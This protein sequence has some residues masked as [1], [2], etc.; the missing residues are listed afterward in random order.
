MVKSGLRRIG[1][2][3]SSNL[4]KLN[5]GCSEDEAGSSGGLCSSSQDSGLGEESDFDPAT[6]GSS[7]SPRSP[8]PGGISSTAIRPSTSSLRKVSSASSSSTAAGPAHLAQQ[9]GKKHVMILEPNLIELPRTKRLIRENG[10]VKRLETVRIVETVS[11]RQMHTTPKCGNVSSQW[12]QLY[13]A[14]RAEVVRR[15]KGCDGLTVSLIFEP[16]SF[17]VRRG[18]EGFVDVASLV[19]TVYMIISHDWLRSNSGS[20]KGNVTIIVHCVQ[21]F[22]VIVADVALDEEEGTNNY[23]KK[24]TKELAASCQQSG[25]SDLAGCLAAT[26]RLYVDLWCALMEVRQSA[27]ARWL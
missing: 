20:S 19:H 13:E 12:L 27:H 1:V 26:R 8:T 6:R 18:V 3:S 5:G 9:S 2:F 16:D 11:R 15:V 24:R 25:Y 14:A 7:T 17:L 10:H 21:A 22:I 23:L 4:K